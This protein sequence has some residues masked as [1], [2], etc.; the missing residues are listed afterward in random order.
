M[1]ATAFHVFI[2]II[3]NGHV[4]KAHGRNINNHIK[5]MK[6]FKY[7]SCFLLVMTLSIILASCSSDDDNVGAGSNSEFVGKWEAEDG[8]WGYKFNENGTGFGYEIN[9]RWAIRWEYRNNSLIITDDDDEDP[10]VDIL[11]ISYKDDEMIVFT[12]DGE[13]DEN[14]LYKVNRFSFE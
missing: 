13:Y 12:F 8:D 6:R 2:L 3:F 11:H 1:T 14:V 7:M 10:D 4:E 9:D 5:T